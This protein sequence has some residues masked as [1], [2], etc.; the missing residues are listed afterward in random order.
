MT[1]D[2]L[3][4]MQLRAR[5]F[6]QSN[7]GKKIGEEALRTFLQRVFPAMWDFIDDRFHEIWAWYRRTF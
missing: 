2:R 4:A 5:D 6:A 7:T 1:D 3:R